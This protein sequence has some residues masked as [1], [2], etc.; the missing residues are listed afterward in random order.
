MRRAQHF[1]SFTQSFD[2]DA[3]P[4]HNPQTATATLDPH[5]LQCNLRAE[6]PHRVAFWVAQRHCTTGRCRVLRF[7]SCLFAPSVRAARL[8][9]DEF[10]AVRPAGLSPARQ[11]FVSRP[12]V[13]DPTSTPAV[14]ARLQRGLERVAHPCS[15]ASLLGVGAAAVFEVSDAL[16]RDPVTSPI[17]A[18]RLRF[19]RAVR[20]S[21]ASAWRRV[22][23]YVEGLPSV[24]PKR[25]SLC[26]RRSGSVCSCAELL[27]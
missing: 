16:L 4:C 18:G 17:V 21:R 25:V 27:W 2:A 11:R 13:S 24:T 6:A 26:P 22:R 14:V 12:R 8:G 19:L 7:Q 5:R 3:E 9:V 23:S 20:M 15:S 10:L 1:A